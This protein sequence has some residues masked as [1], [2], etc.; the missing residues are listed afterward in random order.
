MRM[1]SK[2]FGLFGVIG[3]NGFDA[4]ILSA[5]ASVS[6]FG[7]FIRPILLLLIE[8]PLQIGERARRLVVGKGEE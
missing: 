8:R 6:T 1:T 3:G 7:C 5:S 4:P 2:I